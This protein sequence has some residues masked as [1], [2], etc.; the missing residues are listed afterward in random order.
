MQ[1]IKITTK[2][3]GTRLIQELM[4]VDDDLAANR[5]MQMVSDT[6]DVQVRQA[7][8]EMGWSTPEETE[9]MRSR[10]ANYAAGT[11]AQLAQAAMSSARRYRAVLEQSMDWLYGHGIRPRVSDDDPV[12]AADLIATVL[13]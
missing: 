4:T 1:V 12:T 3:E 11:D 10:L 2:I 6:Q 9:N 8:I 7:L 13:E 5:L